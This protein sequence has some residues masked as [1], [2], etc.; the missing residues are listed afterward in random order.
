MLLAAKS[1][2]ANVDEHPYAFQNE[3][4]LADTLEVV[5]LDRVADYAV[6]TD[7]EYAPY[8]EFGTRHA[9]PHPYIWP[10][11]EANRDDFINKQTRAVNEACR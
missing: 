1:N 5:E 7:V 10:A 3:P 9:P 4:P 11:V 6:V 2:L 8:V